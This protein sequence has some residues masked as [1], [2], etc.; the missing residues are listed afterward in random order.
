M[1]E[2]KSFQIL[3]NTVKRALAIAWR[4]WWW[5]WDDRWGGWEKIGIFVFENQANLHFLFMYDST[6][7]NGNPA[8][9]VQSTEPSP[10]DKWTQSVIHGS[11]GDC[12][13]QFS[14]FCYRRVAKAEE[15]QHP[16]LWIMSCIC[17]FISTLCAFLFKLKS[18]CSSAQ[19]Q[20]E[21]NFL[22]K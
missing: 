16:D 3:I 19:P 7:S 21:E 4:P 13:I 15:Q 18:W 10:Y 5:C 17:S 8:S 1:Q 6:P 22:E 12:I 2:I 20:L 9:P 14:C 11:L